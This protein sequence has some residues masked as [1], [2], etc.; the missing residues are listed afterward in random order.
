MDLTALEELGLS[1]AEAQVYVAL[2]S[3]GPSTTGTLISTT[4]MQSSTVYHT[5]GTLLEKGFVSYILRGKIKYFQAEKPEVFVSFWEERKR[6]L[7]EILPALRQK[8]KKGIETR[9]AKIYEGMKGLRA[10]YD[11]IL[12]TVKPGELYYFLQLPKEKIREEKIKLFYRNY[13]SRRVQKKINVRGLSYFGTDETLNDI[14]GG[15]P[16]TEIR[17]TTEV[18]PTSLV[19]YKNKVMTIDIHGEPVVFVMESQSIA[20]SYRKFF[21]EKWKKAKKF[22]L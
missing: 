15:L 11:D 4:K 16:H 21:E 14:F 18:G 12:E 5:L 8:E 6:K 3:Q 9:S 19:I 20:D 2:L 1:H 10:A 17:M 13:H 7:D 22:S